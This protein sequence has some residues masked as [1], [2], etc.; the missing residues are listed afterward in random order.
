MGTDGNALFQLLEI[1]EDDAIAGMQA[2][3]DDPVLTM[4][5]AERHVD[6]VHL[7]AGA[8]GVD[9]FEALK[10]LHGGLRNENGVAEDRGL[11]AHAAELP[12]TKD[13][14]GVGEGRGDADGAGLL[15]HLAVDKDDAAGVREDGTVGERESER[16][17]RRGAEEVSIALVGTLDE[18]EIF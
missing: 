7:V 3:S 13:V 18:R 2:G 17:V 8:D 4:L 11:S 14:A 6:D 9:L 5:R 10:V 1:A 16:K 12:G 15:V